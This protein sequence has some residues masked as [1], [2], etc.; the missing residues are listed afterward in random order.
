MLATIS[1]QHF[2]G[3]VYVLLPVLRFFVVSIFL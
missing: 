2:I 1:Y 3:H